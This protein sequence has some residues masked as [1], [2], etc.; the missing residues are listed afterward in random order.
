MTDVLFA[1]P[2]SSWWPVLWGPVFAAAGAAVEALGAAVHWVAWLVVGLGLAGGAAGWVRA[3][4]RLLRVALTPTAL[5]EGTETLA[6]QRIDRIDRIG[7][8]VPPGTRVLGGGWTVPRKFAEIPLRLDD[9]TA[10]LAWAR[11]ADGL[12][13]ALRGLV[14]PKPRVE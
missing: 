13:A 12:V 3:R 5:V 4:R 8:E 11:D 7:G 2:G 10:V 6:V 1:E 9:G 14:E